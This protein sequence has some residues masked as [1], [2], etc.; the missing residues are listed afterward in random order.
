MQNAVGI[1]GTALTEEQIGE[2]ERVVRVLELC[3]DADSA[4]QEAM[5]RAARLAER[6]SPRSSSGS[7]PLTEGTDP[8]ELVEREGAD[9]LRALVAAIGAVRR[10]PRRADP[11][12]SRTSQRRGPRPRRSTSSRPVLSE[13]PAEHPARRA[14]AAR[15]RTRSSCP[16]RG[17]P[18]SGGRRRRRPPP[19]TAMVTRRAGARHRLARS[20]EAGST[21]R[22]RSSCSA[23]P[24]RTRGDAALAA[25][26]PDELLTSELLRRAARHLAG[27]TSC[28]AGRPAADDEE[29]ARV[30]ADLVGA[31]GR[32]GAGQRASGSSTP[33]C[34][35]ELARRRPGDRAARAVEGAEGTSE[36]RTRARAGAGGDPAGSVG[37]AGEGRYER[38]CGAR[39]RLSSQDVPLEYSRGHRS[40]R[41]GT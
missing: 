7:S 2:L 12:T 10:L 34:V 32:A 14:D 41:R 17:S 28:A 8:A 38:C 22:R 36:A 40:R 9:A 23:S 29:L 39:G 18:R 16:R 37:A 20:I 21:E 5:L 35:L 13:L 25:I 33:G 24:C 1:M 30:V 27:R 15:R 6:R 3:L 31:R 11:R 19:P 26:D 4:G